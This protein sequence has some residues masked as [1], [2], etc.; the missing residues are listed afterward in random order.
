MDA[1]GPRASIV[2][3]GD[4]LLVGQTVD[5]NA[6]W[7]SERLTAI[8]IPTDRRWTVP[9]TDIAIGSALRDALKIAQVVVFSGGLGPTSDDRTR[10]AVSAALGLDLQENEA[11]LRHLEERFRQRG[12]SVLPVANR[13]QCLVPAGADLLHN[14]LGTAPG[15]A[16][17]VEDAVVILLPGVPRE[18]RAVFD[19]EVEGVLR[20]RFGGSLRPLF[21]HRI[22]TTGIPES[23]L[24]GQVDELL[25]DIPEYLDVGFYPD[26]R[27][28]DLVFRI[29][30][31]SPEVARAAF[32]ELDSVVSGVVGPFRY[33]ADSG[34][35]VEALAGLL[36]S[37]GET[38]CVAESCTGGLIAKRITDQAGASSY[39]YGGVI[40]Y[41]NSVKQGL[42]GVS[43]L[44]LERDGAVSRA[45]AE[46][47]A[48]GVAECLGADVG[49]GVTGV[50][51][52]GGGTKEKPVGTVWYAA[53]RGDQLRSELQTFGGDRDAIR[54]R[55]AQAALALLHHMLLEP[56][57]DA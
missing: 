50:A 44:S 4:E 20:D 8:G 45:V 1:A 36:L 37:R 41:D 15:L 52:P 43:E 10:D 29:R 27:G 42:L 54:E 28:V 49:I 6:A 19:E 47:M 3:V 17:P 24:A 22:H 35:L 38:L 21:E 18:L 32:Q 12:Y 33:E 9:D 7:L 5:T 30:G 46:Q 53:C 55:A 26:L 39:F 31:G 2:S 14:S 57:E 51:G 16:I 48:R 11:W 34:D 56:V 13:G 25:R 23:V 40:A